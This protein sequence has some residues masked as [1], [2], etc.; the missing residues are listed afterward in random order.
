METSKQ[1]DGSSHAGEPTRVCGTSL[2]W[3]SHEL[4]GRKQS[5]PSL[6]SPAVWPGQVTDTSE[7][8]EE[9]L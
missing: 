7:M 5:N 4:G 3:C 9:K 8:P 6:L 2:E 1:Q